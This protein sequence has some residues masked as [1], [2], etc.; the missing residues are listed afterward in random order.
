MLDIRFDIQ[1]QQGSIGWIRFSGAVSKE[2]PKDDLPKPDKYRTGTEQPLDW[3]GLLEFCK[4]EKSV[5]QMMEHLGLKHR[6]TFVKNYLHSLIK[7]K[8]MTIPVKPNSPT[9]KYFTIPP[10][11]KK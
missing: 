11:T 6:E 10:K 8:L 1:L 3:S 2:N 5:K 4:E 9:Q 7:E